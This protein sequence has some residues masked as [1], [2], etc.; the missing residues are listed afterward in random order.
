[1]EVSQVFYHS[2]GLRAAYRA[3]VTGFAMSKKQGPIGITPAVDRFVNDLRRHKPG[4]T[5]PAIACQPCL[6]NEE[7]DSR[8]SKKFIS[9]WDRFHLRLLHHRI[10]AC[11]HVDHEP[12]LREQREENSSS[13][14]QNDWGFSWV[15][16]EQLGILISV[17]DSRTIDRIG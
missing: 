2:G 8:L 13:S 4:F 16:T 10:A 1:M 9:R 5:Q 6:A 12:L 3:M 7:F 11:G 17:G 15:L 14:S